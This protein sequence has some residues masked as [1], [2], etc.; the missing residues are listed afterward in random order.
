MQ[1]EQT[2]APTATPDENLLA[3]L[4]NGAGW[5]YWIAILSFVNSLLFLFGSNLGFP[6]G[7]GYTLFIDGIGFVA[8]NEGAPSFVKGIGLVVNLGIVLICAGFAHFASRAHS[9][10]FIVA[11]VLYALDALLHL[12]L[13]SLASFGFHA[14]ALIWIVR[15]YL[16]CRKLLQFTPAAS[17]AEA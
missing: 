4:K 17:P 6:I 11:I 5:L 10:A 7:L 2:F 14:F 9:W 16:A 12:V 8:V 15:G 3:Q 13:G 1:N